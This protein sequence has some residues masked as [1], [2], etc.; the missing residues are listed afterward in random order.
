[1]GDRGEKT[2]VNGESCDGGYGENIVGKR[3]VNKDK[4]EAGK[5]ADLLGGD[6]WGRIFGGEKVREKG[7]RCF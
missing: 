4:S 6:V 2:L 1:M 7:D 3:R 5:D